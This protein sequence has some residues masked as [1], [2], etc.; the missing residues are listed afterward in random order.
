M[1]CKDVMTY[2]IKHFY[3]VSVNCL[4]AAYSQVRSLCANGISLALP[5]ASHII[6]SLFYQYDT[7]NCTLEVIPPQCDSLEYVLLVHCFAL[8]QC[9]DSNDPITRPRAF[10]DPDQGAARLH[11]QSSKARDPDKARKTSNSWVTNQSQSIVQ[12][13]QSQPLQTINQQGWLHG[14][15]I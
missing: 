11:K 15:I 1:H 14:G 9:T 5:W 3:S 10:C 2:E 8:C 13:G 12:R 4:S 7:S 6:Q